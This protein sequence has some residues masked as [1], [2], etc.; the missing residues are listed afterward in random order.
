MGE[1]EIVR[2]AALQRG[3]R[4]NGLLLVEGANFKQ[5]RAGK[6]FLQ[7]TLRDRSG[8][9]RALQW[10]TDRKVYGTIR[11]NDIVHVRGRVEE[12]QGS[13]QV[14]IDKIETVNPDGLSWE[15]FIPKGKKDPE[16]CWEDLKKFVDGISHLKLRELLVS[17]LEDPRIADAVRRS[18]AGKTLHHAFPG[19]LLEHVV[20]IMSLAHRVADLWPEVDRDILVA[21][22]FLH[23]LGKIRELE[24]ERGIR[25][26]DAGQLVGH[27]AL[28]LDLLNEKLGAIPDFPPELEI[29]LKHL[30]VS[31]HGKTEFGALR[32]PATA[33]AIALCFLDNLDA[34][35]SAYFALAHD[36]VESPYGENWTNVNPLFGTRLFRPERLR[37]N[38]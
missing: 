31:H 6:P 37:R 16:K 33:E 11:V 4:V 23:D 19:G 35:L 30:V 27:V 18:P 2:V 38:E 26:T 34:R 14:V 17:F 22:A 21:G 3:D 28:G 9:I 10:E 5:N 20:G 24:S 32:E 15:E 36:E 29:E 7:L 1:I 8:R 13:R 25:Y 12:Y